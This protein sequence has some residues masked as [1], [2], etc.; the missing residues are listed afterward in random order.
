MVFSNLPTVM[1][2]FKSFLETEY[3]I[4]WT[5]WPTLY[6]GIWINVSDNRTLISLGQYHYIELTL[7][8]FAMVN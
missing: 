8:P 6:L 5:S 7:E 3:D 4:K 2:Q 1:Q